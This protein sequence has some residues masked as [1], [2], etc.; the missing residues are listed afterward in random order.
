[1]KTPA[2]TNNKESFLEEFAILSQAGVGVFL[3]RT[4]EPH[5]V[6][7][8]LMSYAFAVA[9][10]R[11]TNNADTA[12]DDDDGTAEK[13]SEDFHFGAWDRVFG[14]RIFT[15]EEE[16]PSGN[17]DVTALTALQS[18]AAVN[19]DVTNA[20]KDGVYLM[21][22][23]HTEFEQNDAPFLQLLRHYA[24]DV[25]R[26]RDITIVL[27][28]PEG[29]IIPPDI[30]DDVKLLSFAVPSQAELEERT[31]IILDTRKAKTPGKFKGAIK[32]DTVTAL[33]QAGRGLA[34][35]DYEHALDR[36]LLQHVL[37]RDKPSMKAVVRT[38]LH[39]KTDVV[40]RSHVLSLILPGKL[41]DMGGY[42]RLKSF[43]SDFSIAMSP[44]AQDYG[45]DEPK[46][47]FM[48]GLQGSGKT[49]CCKGVGSTLG[50]NTVRFDIGRCFGQYVGQSEEQTEMALDQIIAMAPVI[51]WVDEIDKGGFGSGGDSNVGQKVLGK[52]LTK[53][54]EAAGK[55]VIWLFTA[56]RVMQNGH[57]VIPAELI[58]KGRL[59]ETFFL[60]FPTINERKE[61]FNIHIT[62]RGHVTEEIKGLDRAIAETEGFTGAEIETIVNAGLLRAFKAGKK[63]TNGDYLLESIKSTVPMGKAHKED[64]DA[65][66]AWGA[67][68]AI[69][70]SAEVPRK[71]G[72]NPDS[73]LN[74]RQTRDR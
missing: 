30:Q 1:M 8:A 29:T 2:N 52:I 15:T 53:M 48:V 56:N 13:P 36:G 9:Q 25:T 72:M 32:A 59:D 35:L 67:K 66:L 6:R 11:Q 62:K 33:A 4:R 43:V 54:D 73:K 28:V 10:A 27:T 65:I 45:I 40:K 69:N 18:V 47:I 23:I 70:A 26:D 14:W 12:P 50:L 42:G 64:V 74:V 34:Q 41:N 20:M 51:G 24:H 7:R 31:Q 44:D 37:R 22:N 3:V 63:T 19:G 61:I 68:H 5:R 16:E 71:P 38:I 17:A 58:R 46:G 49:I 21:E 57:S 60:G 39:A 55:G